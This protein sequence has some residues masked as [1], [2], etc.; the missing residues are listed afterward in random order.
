MAT[1][2]PRRQPTRATL[3]EDASNNV[4]NLKIWSNHDDDADWCIFFRNNAEWG[5]WIMAAHSNRWLLRG[6]WVA[7]QSGRCCFPVFGKELTVSF[8]LALERFF[9]SKGCQIE[10]LSSVV[11]RSKDRLRKVQKLCVFG[12][13]RRWIAGPLLRSRWEIDMVATS[14]AFSCLRVHWLQEDFSKAQG[15][16]SEVDWSVWQVKASFLWSGSCACYLPWWQWCLHVAMFV[17]SF[18]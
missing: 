17:C 11:F 1:V 7:G 3:R 15:D 2:T 14:T 13:A 4:L 16:S 6:K 12:L 18:F 9:S 10:R 5:V 8:A